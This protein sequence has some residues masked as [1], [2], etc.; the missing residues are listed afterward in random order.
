MPASPIE[1]FLTAIDQLDRVSAMALFA[2]EVRLLTADGRRSTG[3]EAAQQ[4]L[5]EFLS[6]LR[7]TNH[8]ITDQWH[9]DDVWIAE[10]D[11]SYELR[12]WLALA[13]LPRIFVA[14]MGSD[15]IADLRIY[16]AHERSLMDHRTGEEGMWIGTRWIPPV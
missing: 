5:S 12:D 1:Q 11:A 15:G 9:V 3:T 7:S 13:D 8:R 16:G 6:E 2:P 4:L 10:V 14:R